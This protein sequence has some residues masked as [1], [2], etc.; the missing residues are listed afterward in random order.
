LLLTVCDVKQGSVIEIDGSHLDEGVFGT[1][2]VF[3]NKLI[4]RLYDSSYQLLDTSEIPTAPSC[5]NPLKVGQ[6]FGRYT[7]LGFGEEY[8]VSYHHYSKFAL[9]TEDAIDH[10][11]RSI[12]RD[13]R[14]GYGWWHQAWIWWCGTWELRELWVDEN[15]LDPQFGSLV[16]C[17]EYWA[18]RN[19]NEVVTNCLHAEGVTEIEFQYIGK[20]KVDVEAY[21]LNDTWWNGT[22]EWIYRKFDMSDGDSFKLDSSMV[23]GEKLGSRVMFRVYNAV[24]GK[25]ND[26]IYVRTS[27]KWPLEV[28]PGNIYNENW[29]ITNSTLLIGAN[30]T[31]WHWW[32]DLNWWDLYFNFWSSGGSEGGSSTRGCG[33]KV[34]NCEDPAVAKEEMERV[35][36]NVTVIWGAIK[37]LMT[38]DMVLAK[39][40]Y[41]DAE[42][43]T[44]HNSSYDDE[45]LY[46]MKMAKRRI[47]SGSSE[48]RKGRPHHAITD[49]KHS[50]KN[51]VLAMK[52]T[53]KAGASDKVQE[54]EDNCNDDCPCSYNYPWWM[55][56]YIKWCN[57]ENPNNNNGCGCK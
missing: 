47:Y 3:G 33:W 27:G 46:H 34:E 10:I 13:P 24:S 12:N 20:G 38:A 21:T 44:V 22:W 53:F 50:W 30:Y 45:Y 32:G 4:L 28:M 17:E 37:L 1:K 25:M 7:V 9:K 39:I 41:S 8:G 29:K 31:W 11:L 48:L 19:L 56:W 40:A 35:C 5:I 26:I 43:L 18:A 6:T 15:R 36:S 42:N 16:F 49:Y 51:S 23:P 14:R 57:W 54:P 52:Y 2:G 55:E